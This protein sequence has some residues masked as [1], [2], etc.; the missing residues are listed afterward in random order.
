MLLLMMV[1]VVVVVDT[2]SSDLRSLTRYILSLKCAE[3]LYGS[4][5][6][7]CRYSLFFFF[8]CPV[9]YGFRIFKNAKINNH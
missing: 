2:G 5:V 9:V 8:F 3:S 6:F 7:R 1:I 4:A